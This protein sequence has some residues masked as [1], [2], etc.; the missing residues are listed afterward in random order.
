MKQLTIGTLAELTG[1]STDTL[2][3]YEK[4]KLITGTARSAA[5]YRLYAP[6][7]VQVIWFIRGAKQLSFT[8]D[9]IRQLLTLKTSDQSTCA[10]ILKH[11]EG[12]IKEAEQRIRELKEIKKAL[13]ALAEQCPADD[14]PSDCC[15]ILEHIS[16]N[17]KT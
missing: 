13:K 8:L 10:Q 16:R 15:P 2:R 14:T 7:I 3:Y 17:A 5:G 12:K 11:T 1:V 6:E 4:M 9:E